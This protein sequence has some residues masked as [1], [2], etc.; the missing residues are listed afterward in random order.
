MSRRLAALAAL[1]TTLAACNSYQF[2][3]VG[4]CLIQPGL[5]QVA[6]PK[7]SSADIL[8]EL[9]FDQPGVLH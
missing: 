2:N 1:G 5:V 9:Q 6:L 8:F 7:T 3:P 4:S